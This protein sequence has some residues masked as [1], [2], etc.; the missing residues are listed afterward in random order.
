MSD[1]HLDFW[2]K[3]NIMAGIVFI[4]SAP[5]T[6]IIALN[7]SYW[8]SFNLQ[9]SAYSVFLTS[10]CAWFFTSGK[11]FG[12]LVDSNRKRYHVIDYISRVCTAICP[13][14]VFLAFLLM[15]TELG[16][17]DSG[18]FLHFLEWIIAIAAS[19][20]F[21]VCRYLEVCLMLYD[22]KQYYRR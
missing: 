12:K 20:V 16:A 5:L 9:L 4:A 7:T 2:Q 1:K 21:A 19:F 10:Y 11:V 13:L 15:G 17:D 6:L 18:E 3:F 8:A 22:A 14:F